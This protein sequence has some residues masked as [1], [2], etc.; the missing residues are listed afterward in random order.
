MKKLTITLVLA[1]GALSLLG[2]NNRHQ[3]VEQS[4]QPMQ[5]SYQGVLPCADCSGL[6]TSLFLDSD[7][8]FIL[9]EIYRG[10]THPDDSSDGDQAFAEYGKWARTADKLVLTNGRG[11]KRYFRP[12]GKNLVMLDQQGLPII[13][14]LNYQLAPGDQPLPK[15]PMPLSGMY[16]Y[17]ADAAVFTDCATG[18]TFPVENNIALEKGYL[19]TRKN[20]GEPVF[21][22]LNGHFDVRPSMDEGQSDKTLIPAGDIQ[23]NANKSCGSQL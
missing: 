12:V 18:K 15:T 20:A 4:L 7:G 6:D 9:K 5:Q 3:P 8:T 11:E 10:V 2:C 16:K 23:F 1:V 21:L 13:S 22:T 19:S 17:F 14:T